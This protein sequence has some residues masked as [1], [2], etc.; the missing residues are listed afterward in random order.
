MDNYENFRQGILKDVEKFDSHSRHF[1]VCILSTD[2]GIPESH[3]CEQLIGMAAAHLIHLAAWD[4]RGERAIQEW[5]D[6]DSFFYNRTDHGYVRVR[7]LSAGAELLSKLPKAP[8]GF[9][10]P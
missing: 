10:A 3:V 8:I 7:I 4:G 9:A 5:P 1:R 6:Q 2:Y